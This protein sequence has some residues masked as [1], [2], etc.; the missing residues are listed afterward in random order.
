MKE[1]NRTQSL[2]HQDYDVVANEALPVSNDQ[3][4]CK[5]MTTEHPPLDIWQTTKFNLS[6]HPHCG[7]EATV[8]WTVSKYH[9]VYFPTNSGGT[10]PHFVR[11]S[12]GEISTSLLLWV[13][14]Q[15]KFMQLSVKG[16]T[17]QISKRACNSCS[18]RIAVSWWNRKLSIWKSERSCWIYITRGLNFVLGPL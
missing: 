2:W 17:R 1:K 12:F 11:P 6:T 8:A 4:I 3:W 9:E 13:A 5:N 10:V 15:E 16:G 14:N 7:E 18:W